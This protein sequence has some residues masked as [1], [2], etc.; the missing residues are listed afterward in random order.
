MDKEAPSTEAERVIPNA[1][2]LD[3]AAA[4][5]SL[6]HVSAPEVP[7]FDPHLMNSDYL[8]S[9]KEQLPVTAMDNIYDQAA[10]YF[11]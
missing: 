2:Y 6:E 5:K 7:T 11:N 10:D 1:S 4:A 8:Q 3:P 9:A